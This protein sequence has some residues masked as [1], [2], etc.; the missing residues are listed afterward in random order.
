M[1]SR[2]RVHLVLACF[3][4]L[5]LWGCG[6]SGP[7]FVSRY[8]PWREAE[9]AQCL[10]SGHVRATPFL[11]QRAALGGPGH[12]GATQ[13]F[14]MTAALSGRVAM[15]PA[16]L[17]R[18]PMIPAVD[19]WM[20]TTVMPA[21][22]RN[23]S[24]PVVEIK[25]AASYSC[26]PMNHVDGARLSEHGHANALDVAAFILADGRSISVKKGW[27]GDYRD[28]A[29]LRAV[30]DG[31]CQ[32]FTTVLGPDYDGNHHDHFHVD[33]ARRGPDGLGTV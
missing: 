5:L 9:E 22:L 4:L 6:K 12:C 33:L 28:R 11:V 27:R 19:H 32:Q 17:L 21:A 20:Q 30:R 15:R 2:S 14:E 26:R 23:F 1:W 25:V 3:G 29:F 8:E 18:C 10:R 7:Q 13:P 24:Q 16:A 31:A